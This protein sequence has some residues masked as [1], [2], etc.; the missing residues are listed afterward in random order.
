MD[1]RDV[2]ARRQ[3]SSKTRADRWT[4]QQKFFFSSR[5]PRDPKVATNSGLPDFS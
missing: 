1:E 3:Q 5:K 2:K 4:V